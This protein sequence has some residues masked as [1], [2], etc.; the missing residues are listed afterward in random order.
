MS[1]ALA[2]ARRAIFTSFIIGSATLR[3]VLVRWGLAVAAL[4]A[5][6][7]GC[8]RRERV[9][10]G[11]RTAQVSEKREWAIAVHGGSGSMPKERLAG[12]EEQFHA[13][14][15]RALRNGS[16]MLAG[17]A[18][19]LDTVEAVVRLLE[20]DPLWNAGR[21]AVF[22]HEGTIELDAVIMEG[23]TLRC[24]AVA[25]LTT[26]KNPVTLARRV[27]ERT[28]H[29]F[30]AGAGAEAFAREAAR[31]RES[32]VEIV[33]PSYFRTEERFE[34]LQRELRKEAANPTLLPTPEM[35]TVGA[36]ALDRSGSLAAATSTGGR[37]NKRFGR[38]GDVPV[39][40]AGTYADDRFCAVSATGKGE[41]MIRHYAAA[42]VAARIEHGGRTLEQAVRE[43]VHE[44]LQRGDGGLIAVGP[45]GV[46]VLDFNTEGM[47][48]G[49]ADSAGRFETGIR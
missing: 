34:E 24:G 49:A 1:P 42:N 29:V 12:R 37:T 41:E 36:V 19:S 8:D 33:D 2:N 30:L 11:E 25:G 7:G 13:G 18:S 17:G 31:E 39:I 44:V 47:F 9:A 28:P 26:V 38:V 4:V 35:G 16:E 32:G 21:G 23:K 10:P 6:L 5:L 15:E 27:M 3:P 40:G 46:A 45:D 43:V 14:L 20:D 22:T 48:R